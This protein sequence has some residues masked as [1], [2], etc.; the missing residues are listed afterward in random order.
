[1][2]KQVLNVIVKDEAEGL[3]KATCPRPPHPAPPAFK[4]ASEGALWA[5]DLLR[6]P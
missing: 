5:L 3:A 6:R 1:M 2:A 4:A